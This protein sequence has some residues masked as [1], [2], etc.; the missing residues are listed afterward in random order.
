[1]GPSFRAA[2]PQCPIRAR[3]FFHLSAPFLSSCFFFPMLP[4]EDSGH[5]PCFLR[6]IVGFDN[7]FSLQTPFPP[8]QRARST[9]PPSFLGPRGFWRVT[10]SGYPPVTPPSSPLNRPPPGYF[11]LCLYV[12]SSTQ[13]P[14]SPLVLCYRGSPSFLV[15]PSLAKATPLVP[16]LVSL[17]AVVYL[18]LYRTLPDLVPLSAS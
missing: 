2:F 8:P 9:V 18:Y 7:F 1:V 12:L 14:R 13:E 15:F 10:F 3:F 6:K 4:P 5:H 16:K 17:F 11:D